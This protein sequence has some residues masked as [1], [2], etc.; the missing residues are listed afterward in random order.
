[1]ISNAPLKGM[2]PKWVGGN[3]LGVKTSERRNERIFMKTLGV[4][5]LVCLACSAVALATASAQTDQGQQGQQQGQGQGQ[6]Q[7]EGQ[8]GQ[9]QGQQGEQAPPQYQRPQYQ[10]LVYN[11]DWSHIREVP[12]PPDFFDPIKYIP[13]NDRG[14]YLSLGGEIRQRYENWQNAF[15]GYAAAETLN[16]NLQRYLFDADLHLG[17]HVRIFTQLESALEFGKTGGPWY[18]NKDGIQL[19]QAFVDFRTSD[20][21]KHY[22]LLRVG[23]QEIA[24]GTD[25][26]VSTADFF[27]CR[28]AFDGVTLTIGRGSWTWF[29]QGTKPFWVTEAGA[30]VDPLEHFR[31]SWGG[32]FFAPN[33]FTKQ[34]RTGVFFAALDSKN[35]LWQRGLFT[36]PQ[37]QGR[38]RRYTLGGH[39]EGFQKG[40]D[41]TYEG[42]LQL[43][44]FT[45]VQGPSTS[46]RAWAITT[47]T[48]FTFVKSRHYPRI[49]LRSNIIS[50]DGGHGSLGTFHP[51][52]PDAAY[53]GKLALV[54][55]S[56]V[57]DVTPNFRVALTK[58]V[59]FLSEWSFFW[60]EKTSDAI[61]TPALNTTPV[62]SG[63]T[64]FIEFPAYPGDRARFVG[65]QASVGA[66]LTIDR[67]LTYT[68]GYDYLI[69]G[70]FLKDTPPGVPPGKSVGY[71]V[72]WFTYRF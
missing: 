21:P 72:M 68:L 17:E 23:R 69:A 8:Q 34:G 14:W 36:S 59:Y 61:Y 31:T 63:I 42:I 64:G 67:H 45:P 37:P 16:D 27:N 28:R 24:L 22:T 38:D 66:Q 29:L 1:M 71:F 55:P 43:G 5:S 54:G 26:F 18:T 53:S 9:Q 25:H 57:I 58:R 46:I 7:G 44:T 60:R 15:F 56:N 13:L 51:L 19:H 10:D 52:F 47:E 12:P 2:Y 50:G 40:L 41:Y 48:G 20:N 65:N 70:D 30:F 4:R 39:I 6:G 49:G 35:Q 11:E 62:S 32:G 33:P 3:N